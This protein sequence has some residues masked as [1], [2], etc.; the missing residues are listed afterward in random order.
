MKK[1]SVLHCLLASS[2]ES[3]HQKCTV[4]TWEDP[5]GEFAH[6]KILL[7]AKSVQCGP[8]RTLAEVL[9][10]RS[11]FWAPKVYSAGLW[12]K[13]DHKKFLVGAKTE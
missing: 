11:S 13:V 12:W 5:D 9:L 2:S 4:R 8:G 10:A 6:K 1:V 3:W 7:G